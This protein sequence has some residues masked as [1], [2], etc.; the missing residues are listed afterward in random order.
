MYG[1][2][3]NAAAVLVGGLVGLLLRGGISVRFRNI[4]SQGLALCVLLIGVMN[5]IKTADM[6]CVIV[7]IVLGA[8]LGEALKIEQR[9]D[10]L[11]DLA[12]KRFASGG[13]SRFSE[14]F[15]TATLLYCVGAMAVVGS[16]QAGLTGDA[17]TLLAKSALDGVSSVIFASA[18]G[19]GVILSL[20]PLTIYQGGIALAANIVGPVLSDAVINE[21]SAV[22]G[23]LIVA[24]GLNMLEATKT[25]VRVA[26]LLPAI[27]LPIAY[28][29][30][31]QWISKVFAGG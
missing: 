14:G 29:P 13:D 2:L 8:V 10:R 24:L 15:V 19:P 20:V 28:L 25:R 11:G 27:F 6:M 23:L 17:S 22:G 26:N 18:M 1:V 4:V 31:Y 30:L 16:M 9:L 12:Q 5:A 7:S 3:V 21:M